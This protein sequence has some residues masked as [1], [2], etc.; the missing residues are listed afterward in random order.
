MPTGVY[1]RINKKSE[2]QKQ[3][4]KITKAVQWRRENKERA[5]FLAAIGKAKRKLSLNN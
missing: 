1:V 3:E 5:L 2:I 4:D